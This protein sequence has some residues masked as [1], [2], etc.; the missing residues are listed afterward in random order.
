MSAVTG[1]GVELS[2]PQAG[3]PKKMLKFYLLKISNVCA[4]QVLPPKPHPRADAGIWVHTPL[5]VQYLPKEPPL[6]E[7]GLDLQPKQET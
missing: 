2:Q 3:Q 7:R 5:G 1:V 6:E 4:I